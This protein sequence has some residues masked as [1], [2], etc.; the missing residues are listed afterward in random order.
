[1]MNKPLEIILTDPGCFYV[2]IARA[3]TDKEFRKKNSNCHHCDGHNTACKDY[4][5]KNQI[6]SQV[7]PENVVN[8]SEVAYNC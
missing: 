7:K 5:E 8:T 6:K 3:R 4:K 1:M 2:D